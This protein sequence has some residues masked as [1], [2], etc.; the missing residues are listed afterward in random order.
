MHEEGQLDVADRLVGVLLARS[1]VPGEQMFDETRDVVAEA[2]GDGLR[3]ARQGSDSRDVVGRQLRLRIERIQRR[4]GDVQSG[5][6]DV[7]EAE[8]NR[9][10]LSGVF[11]APVLRERLG[12]GDAHGW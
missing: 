9:A 8:E 4:D 6:F 11:P 10:C 3:L 7:G 1:G 5:V 12:G 2:P